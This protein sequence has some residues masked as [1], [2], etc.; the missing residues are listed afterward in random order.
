MLNIW[1]KGGCAG[2]ARHPVLVYLIL[3]LLCSAL[4][5]VF[6]RSLRN[7]VLYGTW[8]APAFNAL[9]QTPYYLVGDVRLAKLRGG[10]QL[11]HRPSG[12]AVA[13]FPSR[14]AAIDF[15]GIN[16][17]S[18]GT[19]NLIMYS[20]VTPGKSYTLHMR[21][22][23]GPAITLNVA[24]LRYDTSIQLINGQ[25]E[26]TFYDVS[27]GESECVDGQA[28]ACTGIVM[29]IIAKGITLPPQATPVGTL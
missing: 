25:N 2:L 16:T 13:H 29:I 22:N 14:N 10:A 15:L 6:G 11:F 4:L 18:S 17:T 28:G 23:N 19:Y 20:V 3:F 24:R 7:L 8:S 12:A 26:I 9:P 1:K 5:L 27:G 21:V